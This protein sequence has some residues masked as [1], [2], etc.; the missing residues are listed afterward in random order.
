MFLLT[1]AWPSRLLA[2]VIVWTGLKYGTARKT[3]LFR[4]LRTSF[5]SRVNQVSVGNDPFNPAV[6]PPTQRR[7]GS[8]FAQVQES[9]YNNAYVRPVDAWPGPSC[10]SNALMMMIC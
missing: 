3:S 8:T 10:S 4:A 9:S 7:V 1:G 2:A 5:V 6:Q